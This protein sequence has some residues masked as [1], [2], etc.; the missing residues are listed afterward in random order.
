MTRLILLRYEPAHE[1]MALF[2]LCKLILQTH[3]RSHPVGLDVWFIDR[4]LRLLPYS[5]CANS[6]GSGETVR[7][8]RL[9]WAFTGRL[10]EKYHNLMCWLIY[11]VLTLI[12]V[13]FISTILSKLSPIMYH[14]KDRQTVS[15]T[16]VCQTASQTAS[17]PARQTDRQRNHTCKKTHSPDTIALLIIFSATGPWPWP[18]EID[19]ILKFERQNRCTCTWINRT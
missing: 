6:E 16:V 11:G 15:Q 8:H 19:W 18:K 14:M 9:T 10:C 12:S 7:M 2:V 4:T 13:P 3:K 17:L 1:I 5:M